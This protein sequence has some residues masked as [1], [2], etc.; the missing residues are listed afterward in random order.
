MPGTPA[1][2]SPCAEAI[3][4]FIAAYDCFSREIGEE[5]A[6]LE[7][8]R[9]AGVVDQRE[10]EERAHRRVAR[11]EL[12]QLDVVLRLL[13]L[14]DRRDV[15]R[16]SRRT[17]TPCRRARPSARRP[18]RDRSAAPAA[19]RR[20]AVRTNAPSVTVG[21]PVPWN[22]SHSA[23]LIR[24]RFA[25]PACGHWKG[26]EN[27]SVSC[28]GGYGMQVELVEELSPAARR[29]VGIAHVLDEP[30][31]RVARVRRGIRVVVPARGDRRAPTRSSR[32]ARASARRTTSQAC[33]R[34]RSPPRRDRS[35]TAVAR[36]D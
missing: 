34:S 25:A 17:R 30:D 11:R 33:A 32:D 31:R 12:G 1:W 13:R 26:F 3:L 22:A 15:L 6:R 35:R 5:V 9:V 36:I 2:Q 28:T 24:S 10:V 29:A 27:G 4:S 23:C 7:P 16:R 20:A 21:W 19:R 14:A 8:G 18:R